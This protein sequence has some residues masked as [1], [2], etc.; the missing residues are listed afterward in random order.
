[1]RQITSGRKHLQIS[2]DGRDPVVK[3]VP[4][5]LPRRERHIPWNIS[6]R[7]R[8]A[9]HQDADLLRIYG[10]FNDDVDES[11]V[12]GHISQ[13]RRSCGFASPRT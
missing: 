2:F 11:V 13:A 10:V 5:P 9:D 3:G 8:S 4:M 7:N 12:E 1:L 6:P